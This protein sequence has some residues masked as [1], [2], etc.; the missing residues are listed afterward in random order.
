M[1]TLYAVV[2][3]ALVVETFSTLMFGMAAE[4]DRSFARRQSRWDRDLIRRYLNLTFRVA[5]RFA[6]GILLAVRIVQL[7]G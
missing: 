2:F 3:V 4:M 1:L 6:L 7:S 5:F